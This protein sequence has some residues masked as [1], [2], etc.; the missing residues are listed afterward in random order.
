MT[1][2]QKSQLSVAC[3]LTVRGGHSLPVVSESGQCHVEI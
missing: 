3:V 2:F 1:I